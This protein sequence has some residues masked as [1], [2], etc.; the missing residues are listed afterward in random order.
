MT[1]EQ[2]LTNRQMAMISVDALDR[3]G[4]ANVAHYPIIDI[5]EPEARL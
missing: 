3:Y 5:T 2:W 1:A 4:L